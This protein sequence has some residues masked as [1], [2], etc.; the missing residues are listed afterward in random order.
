MSTALSRSQPAESSGPDPLDKTV[1]FLAKRDGIDK[2]QL[3]VAAGPAEVAI[4]L[5][6]AVLVTSQV[7]Y[8]PA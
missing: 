4:I 5:R 7:C 1:L 3:E 8:R 2:V 6:V